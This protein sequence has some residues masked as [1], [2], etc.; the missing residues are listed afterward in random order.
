[1]RRVVAAGAV[2]VAAFFGYLLAEP[3]LRPSVVVLLFHRTPDF[4]PVA[5]Y[6]EHRGYT[7]LSLE[8]LR[9]FLRGRLRVPP[10]SVV[11]TFDDA[12]AT[13]FLGAAEPLRRHGLRGVFF[14]L[15]DRLGAGPPRELRT[16]AGDPQAPAD[17]VRD[18]P[19]DADLWAALHPGRPDPWSLRWSEV[20]RLAAA[21]HD[22][23]SHTATHHFAFASSRLLGFT[24]QPTWR[25]VD[26]L[27]GVAGRGAPL[28]PGGGS[29]LHPEFRPDP[30]MLR[31]L[32][33]AA[34]RHPGPLPVDSLGAIVRTFSAAGRAG[35]MESA[36]EYEA[37][38]GRELAGSRDRLEDSLARPVTALAWPWGT[39]TR[40]LRERARRA[41]YTL[42]FSVEPGACVRGSDSLE[43]P[44]AVARPDTVELRRVLVI[45][46]RPLL[47]RIYGWLHP[48][49]YPR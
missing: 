11:L 41:G 7:T 29:L 31:A 42:I 37:R 19:P 24:G 23:A 2:A 21:G 26:A 6:L 39:H 5:A 18:A 28:F 43:V 32:I 20:R 47:G 22:I 36:A 15:T 13:N 35:R 16:A 38:L 46:S 9:E 34:E 40:A 12:D 44:R 48:P 1:M 49:T 3:V 14:V 30:A 17:T 25:Q 33:R 8:Q 4:E 45:F 27:G 10:R